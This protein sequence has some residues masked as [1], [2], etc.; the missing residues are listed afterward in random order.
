MKK[1][2]KWAGIILG[3]LLLCLG[4]TVLYLN[5]AAKSRLDKKYEV[6]PTAIVIPIDTAS[7]AAGKKWADVLCRGCHG[8]NLAGTKFF[9]VPALGLICASNITPGGV[10]KNYTDLDWDRALRH[11]VGKDGR[12]LLIMPSENFR[13]MSDEHIGQLI[14]YLKTV[15]PVEQTWEPR[16]T[17]LFCCLLFQLGAF[18]GGLNVE[19]I[20]HTSPSHS[21]PKR[22]ATAEYGNYLV[23]INGCRVCHGEQLNGGK[24]P[25]PDAP[26][27]PNLTPGGSLAQWDAPG[28]VHTMRT[29]ITPFGK[30]LNVFMPWKEMNHYDDDQLQ[31]IYAYLMSLPKMEMAEVKK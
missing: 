15:T 13:Y 29:G 27:G 10:A 24:P 31:A 21:A 6:Q 17:T 4:G 16:R 2:L 23:R 25:E 18:G 11:G 7:I 19:T 26:L 5:S 30:E 8:A 20:D 12:P 3:L 1:V 9:D 28:F 14:A 22:G